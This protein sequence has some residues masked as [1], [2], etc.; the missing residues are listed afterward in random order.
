[1][2]D[3]RALLIGIGMPEYTLDPS[4]KM[5][6]RNPLQIVCGTY[7]RDAV[8]NAHPSLLIVLVP[9]ILDHRSRFNDDIPHIMRLNYKTALFGMMILLRIWM[10]DNEA[11]VLGYAQRKQKDRPVL[12]WSA[13]MIATLASN[14]VA[15]ATFISKAARV[16]YR[17]RERARLGAAKTLLGLSRQ[18][19][20]EI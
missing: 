5:D 18:T 1:V 8:T 6:D 15:E 9:L 7:A 11:R 4:N 10:D 19:Q 16:T 14:A 3:L 17:I 2:V 12:F 13:T 20:A